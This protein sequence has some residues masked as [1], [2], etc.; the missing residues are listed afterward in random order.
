MHA[1][2]CICKGSS[3]LKFQTWGVNG[4]GHRR[5]AQ[6]SPGLNSGNYRDITFLPTFFCMPLAV[7]MTAPKLKTLDQS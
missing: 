1:H 2:T 7:K 6:L 5:L 4:N 3:I